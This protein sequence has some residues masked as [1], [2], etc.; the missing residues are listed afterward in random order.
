M[1]DVIVFTNVCAGSLVIYGGLIIIY[2]N[3]WWSYNNI[4]SSRILFR[5]MCKMPWGTHT[6]TG[7]KL[8]RSLLPFHIHSQMTQMHPWLPNYLPDSWFSVITQ[9]HFAWNMVSVIKFFRL[10]Y[11]VQTVN[12]VL[13]TL[14]LTQFKALFPSQPQM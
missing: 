14:I 5:C 8:E 1:G 6:Q 11:F 2:Y 10:F 12:S 4:Q 7:N 13:Y 9:N 3:I